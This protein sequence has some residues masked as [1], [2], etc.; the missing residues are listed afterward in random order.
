[1]FQDAHM[2]WIRCN[3]PIQVPQAC[4][5][6]AQISKL[7]QLA[8]TSTDAAPRTFQE[9]SFGLNFADGV[10]QAATPRCAIETFGADSTMTHADRL[11]FYRPQN[12]AQRFQASFFGFTSPVV[13]TSLFAQITVEELRG[14]RF[15]EALYDALTQ[16]GSQ[17]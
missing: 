1:M 8:I 2:A 11:R 13:A 17:T 5:H 3:S 4:P 12:Y 6:N 14:H 9:N 10:T 15:E 16:A 7:L